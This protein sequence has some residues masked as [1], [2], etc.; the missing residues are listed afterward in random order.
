MS[1]GLAKVFSS[2]HH[3]RHHQ[4]HLPRVRHPN[5][6]SFA[7]VVASTGTLGTSV[8][9][10]HRHLQPPVAINVVKRGIKRRIVHSYRV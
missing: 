6:L 1:Q 4:G 9:L 3:S 8:G 2:R 7:K 5:L 10:L